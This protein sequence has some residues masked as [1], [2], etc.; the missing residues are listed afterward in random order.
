MINKTFLFFIFVAAFSKFFLIGEGLFAFYDELR[1]LKSNEFLQALCQGK[2]ILSIEILF[3]TH[4]RPIY[5]LLGVGFVAVMKI[6]SNILSKNFLSLP[7]FVAL[8]IIN[9]IFHLLNAILLYKIGTKIL[10]S[11]KHAILAVLFFIVS[12]NS[13]IYLR[14]AFPYDLALFIFLVLVYLLLYQPKWLAFKFLPS[15]AFC[16]GFV[17]GIGFLTYPGYYP[18]IALVYLVL[19][20]NCENTSKSFIYSTAG[21]LSGIVSLLVV[22]ETV[23]Y[24]AST[25]LIKILYS[26]SESINQGDYAEGFSFIFSYFLEVEKLWGFIVLSFFVYSI[27]LLSLS[28]MSKTFY[29]KTFLVMVAWLIF[30]VLI[31]SILSYFFKKIVWYGR[32]WHQFLPFFCL[33]AASGMKRI[34]NKLLEFSMA[35]LL[36]INLINF[37]YSIKKIAYPIDF[38]SCSQKIIAEN[39]FESFCEYSNHLNFYDQFISYKKSNNGQPNYV[40]VNS[41]FFYP[42]THERITVLK[43]NFLVLSE[44]KHFINVKAYQYEGYGYSER[45]RIDKM[46]FKIKLLKKQEY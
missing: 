24:L 25:S 22:F 23:S 35:L 3:S 46:N 43:G 27:F 4:G 41:C 7:S 42:I 40:I 44:K 8:F 12:I 29:N 17:S 10:Y 37:I 5:T 13:T 16:F 14:H 38:V 33:I 20:S 21:F 15:K 9:Y 30:S 34:N 19:M 1:F 39:C 18:L 2:F 11:N 26:L 6:V 32:L 36:L 45:Q 28:K 31:H